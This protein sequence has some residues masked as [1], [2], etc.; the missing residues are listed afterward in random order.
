MGFSWEYLST[1]RTAPKNTVAPQ[2]IIQTHGLFLGRRRRVGKNRSLL[3]SRKSLISST[4]IPTILSR[5]GV[6]AFLRS[7]IG[8]GVD[9][10]DGM[11]RRESRRSA[12][13]HWISLFECKEVR[14]LAD[15]AKCHMIHVCV[16]RR[17]ALRYT[18]LGYF[19]LEFGRFLEKYYKDSWC[20]SYYT[21]IRE[22]LVLPMTLAFRSD[23]VTIFSSG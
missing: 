23:P 12:P 13:F 22:R 10:E 11:F 19:D 16:V 20:D 6:V 17:I 18:W 3:L 9:D 4:S 14:L 5:K 7:F 1:A 21:F 2:S 8:D 15:K